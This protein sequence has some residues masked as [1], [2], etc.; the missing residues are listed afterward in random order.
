VSEKN[1]ST[2]NSLDYA[3]PVDQFLVAYIWPFLLH[4]PYH[5][6]RVMLKQPCHLAKPK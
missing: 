3:Y 4:T 6:D 2:I 1:I 5:W